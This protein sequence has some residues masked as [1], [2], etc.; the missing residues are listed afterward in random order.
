[1]LTAPLILAAPAH[2]KTKK[3][4]T[5]PKLAAPV[6]LLPADNGVAD[7]VPAFSWKPVK[8]AVK[9]QFE[10]SADSG[11]NSIVLGQGHG[12]FTTGNTFGAVDKT[13]PNGTYFWHVRGVDA[14]NT[15]GAWS[16]TRMLRKSWTTT[17]VLQGPVDGVQVS[18]P[19]TP[20]VLSWSAVPRAAKYLVYV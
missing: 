1:L 15:A 20:V 5:P 16:R 8:G 19:S 3:P 14:Q 2:A 7:S 10:L 18:Y 17:P 9:Y 4:K 12:S 6:A 13:V 11:F